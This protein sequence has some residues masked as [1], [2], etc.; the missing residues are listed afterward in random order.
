MWEIFAYD[1]FPD[2]LFDSILDYCSFLNTDDLYMFS[3]GSN[4][5]LEAFKNFTPS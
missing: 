4:W 5:F 1:F 3:F 2:K